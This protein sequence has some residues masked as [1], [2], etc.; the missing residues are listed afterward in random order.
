MKVDVSAEVVQVAEV[1][2]GACGGVDEYYADVIVHV[3]V[4]MLG[5]DFDPFSA[6]FYCLMQLRVRNQDRFGVY[7]D[8]VNDKTIASD[9]PGRSDASDSR[10]RR[11]VTVVVIGIQGDIIGRNCKRH[12]QRQQ[13]GQ[14]NYANYKRFHFV[15][16]FP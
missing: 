1:V 3:S 14:R 11:I 12:I 7:I 16:S 4:D 2:K 5:P 15:A 9:R 13:Q 10:P 6:G 8:V